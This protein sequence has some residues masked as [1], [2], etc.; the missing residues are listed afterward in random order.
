MSDLISLRAAF[1]ETFGIEGRPFGSPSSPWIGVSDDAHGVQWNAGI[2]QR[3]GRA[4]FGVNLEGMQYEGWPIARFIERELAKPML[5]DM[6]RQHPNLSDVV[7]SFIHHNGHRRTKRVGDRQTADH[8]ARAIREKLAMGEFRLEPVADVLTL[9]TY[10]NKWLETVKGTLKASTFG[11]YQAHLERYILPA[12]GAHQ[13]ASLRRADCRELVT[14]C[15]A[16]GLKVTSVRGITRTL[17]T[18]L[19]QAVEDELLTANPAFRLG[20]Y[21]R[22]ADDPEREIRP[23]TRVEASL[24]VATARERFPE[25]HPWVLCGLRTGLRAGE[26]LALQW[27]D[28]NWRRGFVQVQRNLVRGQLTSPKNHQSRQVDLSRQLRVV[29]RLWRRQQR[30]AWLKV[31]RPRPEWVFASATGTALDEANVR[32]AFNRILDAAELD[33]RGSHQMRHTAA[34]LL[35]QDGVPITYVSRQ[36]GHKDASITLRVYAHWLPDASRQGLIDVLDDTSSHV[37]QASPAASAKEIQNA[38]S[39]WGR[40]VSRDGIEPSTRRLRVASRSRKR[41]KSE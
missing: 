23:F 12:L 41:S 28:I 15:R 17:S 1:K 36:L 26:L 33:R 32:K 19:S 7:L 37:T 35:L 34:S 4:F 18:I 2:D 6:A 14:R 27:G 16:K 3:G 31:G 24:V 9:E 30:R 5:L 25:W 39:R 13:V 20:K 8:L 21:L 29:L 38:L 11:F 22:S 40:V 10:A